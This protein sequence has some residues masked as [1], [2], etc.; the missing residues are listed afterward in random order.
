MY[1]LLLEIEQRTAKY[2]MADYRHLREPRKK[3]ARLGR[4]KLGALQPNSAQLEEVC[5]ERPL[6]EKRHVTEGC[7]CY[8]PR[9]S[10]PCQFAK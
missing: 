6:E 7:Q 1:T 8:S 9:V 4:W 2:P 3:A 5:P 10:R